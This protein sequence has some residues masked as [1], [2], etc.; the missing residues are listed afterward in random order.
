MSLTQAM[1]FLS[2][3]RVT[4]AWASMLLRSLGILFLPLRTA[5]ASPLIPSSHRDTAKPRVHKDTRPTANPVG[6]CSPFSPSR[7]EEGEE[8]IER[9]NSGK[10]WVLS[11]I[12]NFPL[13]QPT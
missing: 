12:M 2:F 6:I 7:R 4:F 9:G 3:F 13:E 5:S 10:V 11:G 1:M 8:G